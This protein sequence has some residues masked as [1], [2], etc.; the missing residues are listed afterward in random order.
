[1][2]ES[3]SPSGRGQD[4][5]ASSAQ[6]GP[7]ESPTPGTISW[8]APLAWLEQ[9]LPASPLLTDLRRTLSTGAPQQEGW[10]SPGDTASPLPPGSHGGL[11]PAL[12]HRTSTPLSRASPGAWETSTSCQDLGPKPPL[13]QA[14]PLAS[15]CLAA[16]EADA[17]ASPEGQELPTVC[18]DL[19]T[20]RI[21]PACCECHGL[22]GSPLSVL[23]E[24]LV[25]PAGKEPSWQGMGS[26]PPCLTCAQGTSVTPVSVA[27]AA[28]W[29]SQ[30]SLREAGVN[31]SPAEKATTNENTAQTDSLLWHCSR[32][33]LSLL[34]RAELEGRLESTLIIMEALSY[35]IRAAH[36]LR[37]SAAPVGPAEQ[38]EAATQTPSAM[39][40]EAE[41]RL[42]RG[43]Y[44]AG[45]LRF[46]SLKGCQE[47]LQGLGRWLEGA[48]EEMRA[49]SSDSRQL[50]ATVDASFQ[51]LQD[52]RRSLCQQKAMGRLLAQSK[53]QVQQWGQKQEA[54]T[55]ELE[56]ALEAKDAANLVRESVQSEAA[57]KIRTLEQTAESRQR[58]WALLQEAKELKVDLLAGYGCHVAKGDELAAALKAD[59][60]RMRLDY[61]EYRSVVSKC[62]VAHRK[63]AEEVEA[64]RTEGAQ[65]REVC[66]K[67]EET[68]VE[69]VE[70]LGRV[71]ELVE[72][73]MRLDRE[74][75]AA[76]D[77]VASSEEQLEQLQE[78]QLALTQRLEEKTAAIQKLQDEAA[79]LAQE[80]ERAQQE[81]DSV[82]REFREASDCREFLEQENQVARRQLSETEEELKAS[83]TTLRER[84]S[85]LEDLKEAHQKLQQ[86]QESLRTELDG[87]RAEIQETKRGL[88]RL[89]GAVLELGGLH[90]QFLEVTDILQMVRPDEAAQVAPQSSTCTPARPTPHRLRVSLVDS[91]LRAASQG[92]QKTPGLWSETTAFV[93][94]A[95]APPPQF[96]EIQAS[97]A[98]CT[99]DLHRAMEQLHPLARR[100]QEDVEELRAQILQ[101]KQQLEASQTQHQAEMDACHSAQTKLSKVLQ[102]KIQSEKELQELLRQQEEK[103]CR[104]SDQKREVATLQEEV[105]QL[106]LE[107]QKS[108]TEATTLWDEMS[109]AHRPDVQEK[110]WLRQE[111]GKLK[112]QLLQKDTERT[113]AVTSHLMQVRCLEERLC[114]AQQLLRRQEK[115]EANLKQ[116]LSTLPAQ[117]SSLAEVQRLLDLLV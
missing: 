93:R 91:V 64:A 11:G 89:S 80:K 32:D 107:L 47:K 75:Q 88:E 4:P 2:A 101:L 108:K 112:E 27:S 36:E 82:Q 74:L 87:A 54:M 24:G 23:G 98:S 102:L 8:T 85:Q 68:T 73:N 9:L 42:Y 30:L 86:E 109:G 31:T 106:K 103:Q 28:A 69:L 84:G 63:M 35:Q 70:A 90:A 115:V 65:H 38:R 52:G 99:Q 58:L 76:L 104:Q 41:E 105:A 25:S 44:V 78:E 17:A 49:W 62:L 33:Q 37:P 39:S 3:G 13:E 34:S 96:S 114:Q 92:A 59:W 46:R 55:R 12:E 26:N 6:N 100:C 83:L 66:Q 14:G 7:N 113:Q 40:S 5:A 51:H 61:Q 19:G 20:A 95:P 79:R 71:N 111:V 72:S 77:K 67:L 81:R 16:P 45:R 116:A 18:Q 110:I 10:S 50:L 94:A 29:T 57:S 60:A 97:L 1:M 53:A 21:P 15:P 22:W 43:L 56:A 117:V 48:N